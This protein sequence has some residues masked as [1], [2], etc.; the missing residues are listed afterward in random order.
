MRNVL[1][2]RLVRFVLDEWREVAYKCKVQSIALAVSQL[3]LQKRVMYEWYLQ[4]LCAQF[5]QYLNLRRTTRILDQSRDALRRWFDY[6]VVLRKRIRIVEA[7]VL[8]KRVKTSLLTWSLGFKRHP[9][10]LLKAKRLAVIRDSRILSRALDCMRDQYSQRPSSLRFRLNLHQFQK[11]ISDI[12]LGHENADDLS[13]SAIHPPPGRT[14]RSPEKSLHLTYPL[15]PV[16]P[17][18]TPDFSH[19]SHTLPSRRS[20]SLIGLKRRL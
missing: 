3:H 11:Y 8:V 16:S 20:P 2:T 4:L 14:R 13:P 10:C 12:S 19:F 5:R 7:I 1:S 18:E 9:E 15:R 6:A 17:I